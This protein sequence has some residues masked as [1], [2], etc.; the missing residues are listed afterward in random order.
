MEKILAVLWNF[1]FENF[2]VKIALVGFTCF[3]SFLSWEGWPFVFLFA[4]FIGWIIQN[5]LIK[6]PKV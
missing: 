4:M 2:G 5:M 3:L 6:K 1:F